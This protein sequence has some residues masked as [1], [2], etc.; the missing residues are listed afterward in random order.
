MWATSS[1]RRPWIPAFGGMTTFYKRDVHPIS[2][3]RKWARRGN[4][5]DD[6]V[7]IAPKWAR[8]GNIRA[9]RTT[10]NSARNEKYRKRMTTN[11]ARNEKYRKRMTTNSARG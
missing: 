6:P 4:I 5:R 3:A 7:S 9:L 11:S 1:H 2:I 8:R 10:T